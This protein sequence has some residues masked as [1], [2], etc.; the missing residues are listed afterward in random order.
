MR[1]CVR[2]SLGFVLLS[3]RIQIGQLFPAF[4]LGSYIRQF[5]I[6]IA[7]S[8][9][10]QAPGNKLSVGAAQR[11]FCNLDKA[12][13]Q[14]SLHCVMNERGGIAYSQQG[15]SLFFLILARSFCGSFM[16]QQN[17]SGDVSW[18]LRVFDYSS[19]QVFRV[20]CIR[21][22]EHFCVPARVLQSANRYFCP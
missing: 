14:P 16:T 19:I 7:V 8:R 1:V 21:V 20:F 12:T 4:T 13:I 22:F 6:L 17:V 9:A 10:F 15:A 2:V 11:G 5:S 18:I 3:G